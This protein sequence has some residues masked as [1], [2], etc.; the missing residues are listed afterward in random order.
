M[1]EVGYGIII[2]TEG[3]NQFAGL[4]ERISQSQI[5]VTANEVGIEIP[6]SIDDCRIITLSFLVFVDRIVDL[7]S[8]EVGVWRTT[9]KFCC[10]GKIVNS[11]LVVVDFGVRVSS[12][13]LRVRL[14]RA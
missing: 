9:W 6:I 13:N 4:A 14:V 12:I 1:P 5:R 10:F 7:G 8:L 3:L 2:S 11:L